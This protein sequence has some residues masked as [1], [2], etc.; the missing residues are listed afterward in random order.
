MSTKIILFDYSNVGIIYMGNNLL[1]ANYLKKG[2]VDTDIRV[3][4][5]F[6]PGYEKIDR[7]DI[8]EG[9]QHFMLT[10]ENDVVPL[11][12]EG[13]NEIYLERRRLVRLRAFLM[14]RLCYYTWQVSC[15]VKISPWEGFE[16]HLQ[17]ALDQSD[18][19]NNQFSDAVEE[20]AYINDISPASAYKEL[21]LQT[22][23]I[24]S[25]KMRIYA[26][27]IKFSDRVNSIT[28][29]SQRAQVKEEIL[30]RFWRDSWI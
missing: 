2:L 29:D 1:A 20:Y 15:K 16:N 23:N 6:H 25:I 10:R 24:H 7:S 27:L 14:E 30:D 9:D 4:A 26:S 18:F 13:Q 5:K 12:L 8:M 21:K 11:T 28:E 19:D 3:L 22:E 17:I